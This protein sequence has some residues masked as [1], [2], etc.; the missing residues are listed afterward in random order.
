[1]VIAVGYNGLAPGE[2][3]ENSFWQDR[4]VRRPFMVHAEVN[5]L[6][7]CQRGEVDLLAVTLLPCFHCATMIAA[8]GIKSVIYGEE[9]DKDS[10]AHDI[11]DFYR[12]YI[13]KR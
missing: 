13:T 3:I 10:K 9:Y 4:D 7:M 6:S 1:M 8:Y 5:C 12:P 2:N 11:F